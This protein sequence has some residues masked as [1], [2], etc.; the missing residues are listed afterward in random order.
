VEEEKSTPSLRESFET[1]GEIVAGDPTLQ[2]LV[3][4]IGASLGPLGAFLATWTIA[5]ASEVEK[6]RLEE[7]LT[8]LAERLKTLEDEAV[9]RDFLR[10]IWAMTCSSRHWMRLAKHEVV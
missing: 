1:S 5:K 8:L 2:S 7:F 9:K 6:R 4:V 10:R 3:Q